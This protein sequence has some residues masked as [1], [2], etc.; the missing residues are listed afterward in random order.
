ML[1]TLMGLRQLNAAAGDSGDAD[2]YKALVCVFLYGGND[3]ANMLIPT[4]AAPY[5]DY[6]AG[7]GSFT[8]A[9]NTILDLQAAN[10]DGGKLGIHPSMG[11]LANLSRQGDAAL[12]AN[13]GTLLAPTTLDQFRNPTS[14]LPPNLISHNDK[15]VLWRTSLANDSNAFQP[16]GWGGRI[17]DL[18]HA[19]HNDDS[20][21]MLISLGGTN[22][23]QV[24]DTIQPVRL[25]GGGLY[26]YK[27]GQ[28]SSPEGVERYAALRRILDEDY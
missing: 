3:A 28:D 11:G 22:F 13:V 12:I 23:F 19:S 10:D 7:R 27:L 21:S 9:Q 15:K 18:L 6:A 24:A 16:N 26:A 8:L 25:P 2:D 14:E 17:A 1:S 5:A 20:L 4:A